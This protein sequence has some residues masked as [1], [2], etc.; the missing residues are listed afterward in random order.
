MAECGRFGDGVPIAELLLAVAY[1]DEYKNGDNEST[2]EHAHRLIHDGHDEDHGAHAQWRIHEQ[3]HHR[4][5]ELRI[6]RI[7]VTRECV[8]Y[9]ADGRRVEKSH[10]GVDHRLEHFVVQLY[11]LVYGCDGEDDT[12]REHANGEEAYRAAVHAHEHL[13]ADVR[14]SRGGFGE[15]ERDP[16][17]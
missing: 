17:I 13:V 8:Q 12:A 6:H 14:V 3:L 1:V 2:A 16:V 11:G 5:G 15:P 9:A 7:L 4:V 10:F